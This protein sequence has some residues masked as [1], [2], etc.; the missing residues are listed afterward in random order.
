MRYDDKY[1]TILCVSTLKLDTASLEAILKFR[2]SLMLP[3]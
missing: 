3:W 1:K 2:D